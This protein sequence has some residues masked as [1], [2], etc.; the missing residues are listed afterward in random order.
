MIFCD[1][2][3]KAVNFSMTL[4]FL[5]AKKDVTLPQVPPPL[6]PPLL[7]SDK[8]LNDHKMGFGFQNG[9]VTWNRNCIE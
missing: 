3:F 8:S 9:S 1:P 7:I 5:R 6:P 2:P 4:P